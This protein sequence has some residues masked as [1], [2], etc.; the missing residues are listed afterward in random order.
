MQL[1]VEQFCH[2]R[3]KLHNFLFDKEHMVKKYG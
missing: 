3:T 1:E 2:N